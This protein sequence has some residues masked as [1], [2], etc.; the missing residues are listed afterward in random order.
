MLGVGFWNTNIVLLQF[1]NKDRQCKMQ[2]LTTFPACVFTG[3]TARHQMPKVDN[4]VG[5]QRE[6]QE[7]ALGDAELR[8]ARTLQNAETGP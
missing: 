5:K 7:T 4:R 3:Q 1:T 2:R 6:I 8:V